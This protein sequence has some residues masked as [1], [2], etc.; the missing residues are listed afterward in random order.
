MKYIE[1]EAQR[2][3]AAPAD[4]ADRAAKRTAWQALQKHTPKLAASVPEIAKRFGISGVSCAGNTWGDVDAE[5]VEW[6]NG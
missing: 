6:C 5:D 3:A 2:A 1:T 4:R